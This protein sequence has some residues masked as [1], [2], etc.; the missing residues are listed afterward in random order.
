MAVRKTPAEVAQFLSDM[1]KAVNAGKISFIPRKKNMF[2]LAKLGLTM[3]DVK[4]EL[5][6]LSYANYVSG[7][8]TD[9]DCPA[10]D[11]FWIF[12]TMIDS[13]CIYIKVKVLYQTD[14]GVKIVSFH[15]DGI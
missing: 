8:E 4:D 10:S 3:K 13:S 1:K 6:N 15:I 11:C 2:T 5:I 9:Y 7:P 14:G 12:K